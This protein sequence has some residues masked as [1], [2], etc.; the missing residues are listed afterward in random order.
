MMSAAWG[1]RGVR[2]FMEDTHVLCLSLSRAVAA[3]GFPEFPAL[4]DAAYVGAY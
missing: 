4:L 2:K 3:T 1:E